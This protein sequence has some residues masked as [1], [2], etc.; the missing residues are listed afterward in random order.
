MKKIGLDLGFGFTKVYTSNNQKLKFPS[1]IAYASSSAINELDKVKVGDKWFV[2][3]EDAKY[4]NS[5]ITL[6]SI[7]DIIKY[8]PVIKEYIFLKLQVVPGT[9]KVITGLPPAEKEKA[10]YLKRFG[11]EV[12]PQGLGIFLDAVYQKKIDGEVLVID[13]GQKTVDYLIAENLKK[14][15]GDTIE[16]GV[17]RLIEIFRD[18]LP[19]DLKQLKQ[20]SLQRLTTIFEKGFANIRGEYYDL[21]EYKQKAI[22]E[23]NE[24]LKTRLTSEVGN[25]INEA[26]YIVIAGGGAYYV[27]DIRKFNIYIPPEPEFSQARGYIRV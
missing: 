26:D 17:E 22:E 21:S 14:K 24:I 25:F 11:A 9:A 19:V 2:V 6:S 1:W 5:R 3:G 12:I 7:D 16:L 23:Y 15:K 10:P 13:I 4:E 27:K 18:K 20:Y 8:F